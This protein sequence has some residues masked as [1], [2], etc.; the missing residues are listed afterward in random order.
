[1]RAPLLGLGLV[2]VVGCSV[3]AAAQQ[4]AAP[5]PVPPRLRLRSTFAEATVIPAPFTCLA[6]GGSGVSPPLRWFNVP[7][8]TA[9]FVITLMNM[10][11]HPAKG[12][13]KEAF[14]VLWNVPG[15][16][17]ELAEGVPA[18]GQLPDGSR[19]ADLGR[20][21]VRYRPPCP[22]PGTGPLHYMFSLYA[23]DQM[24]DVPAGAARA[25]VIRA[26]DGHILGSTV[27]LGLFERK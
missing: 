23:L 27:L 26:M 14:W 10:D 8:D 12:L 9:S 18:G 1:V 11:N 2:L 4:A 7:K 21:N 13:D 25:D 19:Q 22:P 17:T 15:S 6:E 24:L 16:A 3:G 20:G 5:T